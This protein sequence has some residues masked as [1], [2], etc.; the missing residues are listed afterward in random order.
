MEKIPCS[1]IRDHE[2]RKC[3]KS[4]QNIQCL[5]HF[6]SIYN[7]RL[8]MS[9]EVGSIWQVCSACILE[10]LLHCIALGRVS[11]CTYVMKDWVLPRKPYLR[12][13]A[14][15]SGGITQG[16]PRLCRPVFFFFFFFFPFLSLFFNF[17]KLIRNFKNV[18]NFK[19]LIK[20]FKNV[21]IFKICDEISENVQKIKKF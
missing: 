9:G 13:I 4:E 6:C 8:V 17:Q 14:S 18:R 1:I 11:V 5:D 10:R 21:P 12:R 15:S 20:K 3:T 16:R 19:N 2:Q 7:E